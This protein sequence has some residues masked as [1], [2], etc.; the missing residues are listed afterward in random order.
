MNTYW[1]E[2][3]TIQDE[4]AH[5]RGYMLEAIDDAIP[6]I[7]ESIGDIIDAR[8]KGLRPAM[9]VLGAKFGS[10][11]RDRIVPIAAC[12]EFLHI[13]TLIHDDIIDEAKLRR[14]IES[15]QSKYSKDVAVL[16][17]DYIFAKVFE[18]LAGDYPAEMLKNLSKSILQICNGELTQYSYRYSDRMDL[19]KYIE[20]IAG[21]TAALFSMSL[22]AGAYEGKVKNVTIRNLT[23]IGY[24]VGMMFQIIDDCL[25]YN[26][27]TDTLGKSAVN[28]IKQGYITLPM[29][30]ALQNDADKKLHSLIFDSDLQENDIHSIKQLV[31]DLGGVQKA[32][33]KAKEYKE[34]AA[35][36][37]KHLKRSK[38]K[39]TLEY[40]VES[41]MHREF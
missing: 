22:F 34:D 17:G 15:V 10:Y 26:Q 31:I 3:P 5:V 1:E 11:D 8:G 37:L 19:D 27:D 16:I 38:N 18:L 7:K 20:I 28:D 12:V 40:I 30:Y 35:I 33:D 13:A 2:F 39:K 9:V 24:C 32:Q 14:G 6:I 41:M 29:Y 36:A 21:K 23:K 4:L 25:D